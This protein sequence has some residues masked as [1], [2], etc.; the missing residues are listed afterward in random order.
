MV[1]EED[2]VGDSAHARE[3]VRRDDRRPSVGCAA[4]RDGGAG[5]ATT[6]VETVVDEQHSATGESLVH[7]VMRLEQER[8]HL[9]LHTAGVGT[10]QAGEAVE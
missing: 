4:A 9:A 8:G 2:A 10:A 5:R 1:E 7:D 3:L 6:W